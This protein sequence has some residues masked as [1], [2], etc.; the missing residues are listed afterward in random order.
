VVGIGVTDV[1]LVERDGEL[2]GIADRLDLAAGGRGGL[3]YI[4]GLPGIGKTALM[5]AT[6]GVATRRGMRVLKARGG[7][8]E[9][10]FSHGVV[11]QLFETTLLRAE[12]GERDA[13][14]AGAAQLAG[15]IFGMVEPV[16]SVDE[17]AV[18]HGLYWLCMNLAGQDPLLLAIDDAHWADVASLRFAA[19]L[20]RR[21][22]DVPLLL[23][24][25]ARPA[26]TEG[27]RVLLDA[28]VSASAEPVVRPAPLSVE[29]TRALLGPGFATISDAF[30]RACHE[31]TGGNLFLLRQLADT[32]HAQAVSTDERGADRVRELGPPSVSASVSR[33]IQRLPTQADQLA[34]AVAVLGTA[35]PLRHAAS[36][37]GLDLATAA[38]CAD[39]LADADILVSNG[40]LDFVHPIVRRAV[41]DAIPAGERSLAHARAASLL[42]DA[43]ADAESAAPHLLATEP[44]AE[45]A[46]VDLLRAAAARSLDRGDPHAAVTYLRRAL[47]EPPPRAIR[48]A[49]LRELGRAW[50]TAGDPRGVEHLREAIAATGDVTERARIARELA[51]GLV[52]L[53][54]Y[55]DAVDALER[56]VADL[57]NDAADPALQLRAELATVARLHPSTRHLSGRHG[58][59][60][61]S[62]LPGSTPAQ[63]DALASLA[64]HRLVAGA[65]ATEVGTL[66]ARALAGGSLGEG[67]VETFVVYDALA[68]LWATEEIEAAIRAHDAA[69]T[70]ARHCGSLIAFARGSA[71]RAQLRYRLGWLPEAESDARGSLDVSEPDWPVTRMAVGGLIEVLVDRGRLDEADREL[72]AR[73]GAGEIPFTFMA[74]FLL[75]ARCRL[76]V[77]QGRLA[78]GLADLREFECREA[79]WPGRCPAWF[80]YRSLLALALLS[81]EDRTAARRLAT[82]EVDRARRWGSRGVLGSALRVYGLVNGGPSG[83]ASLREAVAVLAHSPARLEHARAVTDLGAALRR[84][85]HR[86]SAREALTEGLDLASRCGADALAERARAELRTAGARPRRDRRTGPSALTAAELRVARMACEGMTNREIAQ[87]LFVTLRTVQLHL[88]HSYQKLGITSRDELG[89]ALEPGKRLRPAP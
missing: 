59:R 82:E 68:A 25:A 5:S 72:R 38:R 81:G 36:L 69:L 77:A 42:T 13:L 63:R 85:G 71:F 31:V 53:G 23:A 50:V 37:A 34:R 54:R 76:R 79:A 24:V 14:L 83:I 61:P 84:A 51:T 49:L 86:A 67:A 26:E 52:T 3:L 30:G 41:Y 44:R 65:P 55:A 15:P 7:E 33:R 43:G 87:A 17:H 35:T 46:V 22:E 70:S 48:P 64:L 88:T 58:D 29:G 73:H 78:D 2:A 6:A 11:R 47:A 1:V 20:A 66:A 75:W 10:G 60:L 62:G 21:L 56:A 16:A 89:A 45:A 8:L 74:N 19:Y 28:V 4:E 27:D 32:L 80:P 18:L 40:P 39:A 57:P 12:T 9:R